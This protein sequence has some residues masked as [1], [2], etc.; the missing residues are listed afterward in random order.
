MADFHTAHLRLS[1]WLCFLLGGILIVWAVAEKKGA[2]AADDLYP[3]VAA[4][5]GLVIALS[6][7]YLDRKTVPDRPSDE[8]PGDGPGRHRDDPG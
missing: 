7:S 2:V 1:Q 4:A 5:A 6:L 3:G 8:E